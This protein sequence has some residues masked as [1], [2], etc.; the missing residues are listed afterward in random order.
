MHYSHGLLGRTWHKNMPLHLQMHS[1]IATM[2][3][4]VETL[5]GR[6]LC[7]T[8]R[9]ADV[10]VLHQTDHR[11]A[12]LCLIALLPLILARATSPIPHD[13]LAAFLVLLLHLPRVHGS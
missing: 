1:K 6:D 5:R 7:L 3:L 10:S 12:D 11:L 13:K 9:E 2:H 8:L 4:V